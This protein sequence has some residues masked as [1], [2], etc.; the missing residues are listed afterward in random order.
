MDNY[1][2]LFDSL[3]DYNSSKY[4]KYFYPSVCKV[5]NADEFIPK[6]NSATKTVEKAKNNIDPD[7]LANPNLMLYLDAILNYKDGSGYWSHSSTT[8]TWYNL[9]PY[10]NVN[11]TTAKASWNTGSFW[12]GYGSSY[13]P[14][15]C[16]Y[17]N[18]TDYTFEYVFTPFYY[19][20]SSSSALFA[21]WENGGFGFYY[22]K[23]NETTL[24]L[25][26][27]QWNG[28]KYLTYACSK[29]LNY[30][31]KYLVTYTYNNTSKVGKFYINGEFVNNFTY[32]GSLTY[33]S[34]T[35][36]S[37]GSNPSGTNVTT[38]STINANI[39]SVKLYNTVLTDEQIRNN[40][41]YEK[42]RYD[43]PV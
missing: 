13:K 37:I 20:T 23:Q 4:N 1:T 18:Y 24:K 33:H 30:S 17:R 14:I 10:N 38:S 5:K 11:A 21:C 15:N 19:N 35:V 42:I 29:L 9:S 25:Q 2:K 32:T 8:T 41:E 39:Y 3:E 31:Q 40:F 36:V 43:I 12:M 28:S 22:L 34:T 6:Y 27:D 7:I 26:I 16:G